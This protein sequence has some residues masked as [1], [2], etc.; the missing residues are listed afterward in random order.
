MASRFHA[1]LLFTI[2]GASG[3]F[4]PGPDEYYQQKHRSLV[5]QGSAWAAY[6]EIHDQGTLLAARPTSSAWQ[7][8]AEGEATNLCRRFARR[9]FEVAGAAN[10][11]GARRSRW[12]LAGCAADGTPWLSAAAR[13]ECPLGVYRAR[14]AESRR[15]LSGT[16][17]PVIAEVEDQES[18][19]SLDR[20][21]SGGVRDGTSKPGLVIWPPGSFRGL[22]RFER[23]GS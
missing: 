14:T 3:I 6:P 13:S 8:R 5:E 19:R 17:F 12:L 10:R 22:Y 9:L 7:P 2:Q 1:H 23:S 20:K 11:E 16:S 18:W 21:A 4:V 15:Q